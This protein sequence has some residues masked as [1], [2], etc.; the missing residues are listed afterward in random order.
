MYKGFQRYASN[1]QSFFKQIETINN[2]AN[3]IDENNMKKPEVL[4][5]GS[6]QNKNEIAKTKYSL[7]MPLNLLVR[8][9]Y[10]YL[11]SSSSFFPD[12]L[13]NIALLIA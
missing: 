4:P 10:I 8:K 6:K 3:E 11:S 7:E 5:T 1:L 9:I 2:T 12:S 13:S